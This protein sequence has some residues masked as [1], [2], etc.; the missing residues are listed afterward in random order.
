MKKTTIVYRCLRLALT[1]LLMAGTVFLFKTGACGLVGQCAKG[2][3]QT[4]DCYVELKT[5]GST[6]TVTPSDV[7]LY[8]G[9]KL[10]WRRTDPPPAKP[11]F[12]VDFDSDDCTPFGGVFHFDQS[13]SAP[14]AD[15]LGP[16]KFERC[17]YK[18][19]IDGKAVDPHVIVIGGGRFPPP[20][21]TNGEHK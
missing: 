15:H 16:S 11:D 9:I 6:I 18:V 21:H 12:S 3:I 8:S 19:T 13:T 10:S 17:K 2:V 4:Q 20:R 14:V 1:G 5:S 7:A